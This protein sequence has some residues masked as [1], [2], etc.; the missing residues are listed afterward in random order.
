MLN[1]VIVTRNKQYLMGTAASTQ[2]VCPKDYDE[3]KF[4]LILKLF[5]KLDD[6]GDR[7]VETSELKEISELHVKNKIRILKQSLI[8]N[9][10]N[11]KIKLSELDNKKTHLISELESSIEKEKRDLNSKYTMDIAN[12]Q[13]KITLYNDMTDKDKADKFLDAVSDDDNKIEF[14][15]FFEYMK[16][17]T[18]DI[19]NIEF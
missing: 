13:S 8:T 7:V 1:Y 16:E 12:I 18:Q 19:Q 14:D 6:N 3:D 2:L 15:K 9:E 11:L 17:K 4:K 10:S 5:D